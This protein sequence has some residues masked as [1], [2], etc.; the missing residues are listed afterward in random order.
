VPHAVAMRVVIAPDSFKGTIDAPSAAARLA[1]GWR[2]VRPGDDVVE[3]PMADGGE[4]TLDVL[5]AANPGSARVP[6][7][8]EGPDGRPVDAVFLRLPNGTAVVELAATSGITLLGALQPFRAQTRGFGTA[9]RAAIDAGATA[10]LLSIG[11]SASTDGGAGALRSLGARFVDAEGHEVED[12]ADGLRRVVEVDLTGLSPVPAGGV[13]V[14]TDVDNP[15]LG[16]DG[17]AAV[18]GPQK[19]ASAADVPALEG[20][21]A[22]LAALLPA[23]PTSP[24]AGAAGG[25]G[26]GL[27]AWGASLVPGGAAVAEAAGLPAAIAGSDLVITGEGR[28]DG[29]S[30]RGKVADTVRS[31]A[32]GAG[33]RAALVAGAIEADP[34]G[35]VAAV[36]LTDLVGRDAALADPAEALRRAGADLARRVHGYGD[37]GA[38][39]PYP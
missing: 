35:F 10:L 38:G 21:L 32:A 33:V 19:G 18:Y 4:G 14:L 25:T 3:A 20:A 15:L 12:G 9:I 2:S 16:P 31:L 23:D 5:A 36:S 11:G 17:A 7:R 30:T 27:L 24:G 37:L 39:S 6:V 26:F 29:Q 8:V 22:R 1:D 13:R 34:A 28:F